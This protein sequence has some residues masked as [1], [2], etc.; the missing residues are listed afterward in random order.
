MGK[1]LTFFS[2]RE[3]EVLVAFRYQK[4]I[5]IL[6]SPT[7]DTMSALLIKNVPEKL[8]RKLKTLAARHH[9]SMTR[10]ALM[11]LEQGVEREEQSE[12]RFPDPIKLS[13]PMTNRFI[14]RAKRQG[15]L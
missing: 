2:C 14:D 10:E 9:R 12:R 8:S 13:Y 3:L 7:E 1:K 4:D 11:L 5:D 15:R 6:S